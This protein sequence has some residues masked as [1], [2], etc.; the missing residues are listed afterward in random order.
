MRRS[1][2]SALLGALCLAALVLS[3]QAI[4]KRSSLHLKGHA[5]VMIEDVA[6]GAWRPCV[7]AA[8]EPPIRLELA[9]GAALLLL[10]AAPRC[11][12]QPPTRAHALAPCSVRAVRL[13]LRGRH[14]RDPAA[15]VLQVQGARPLL[16][17]HAAA[18][19][20]AAPLLPPRQPLPARPERR[21]LWACSQVPPTPAEP[22]Q[23][24]TFASDEPEPDMTFSS[25]HTDIYWHGYAQRDETGSVVS[26]PY[27][28]CT[29]AAPARSSPDRLPGAHAAGWRLLSAC[30]SASPAA[31]WPIRPPARPP[32]GGHHGPGRGDRQRG[33]RRRAVPERAA[34]G[35]LQPRLQQGWLRRAQHR[36]QRH[37]HRA[38][39]RRAPRLPAYWAPR[40]SATWLTRVHTPPAAGACRSLRHRQH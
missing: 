35:H 21:L 30:S 2:T 22:A 1:G 5:R 32:A 31:R 9:G 40:S 18:P 8:T 11:W 28:A 17:G 37:P 23:S 4:P 10:L 26:C 39:A 13:V 34:L 14:C 7:P 24:T 20:C 15:H 38:G 16:A 33:R 19:G 25:E 6:P 3:G 27:S 12:M 36:A 29:A